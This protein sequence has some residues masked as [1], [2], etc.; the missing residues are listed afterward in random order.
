MWLTGFDAPT[1][2]TLYLDKPL[3]NHT[4]MQTIARA[5][6]VYPGKSAG[7]VIDYINIFSALQ[8]ALGLYGGGQIAEPVAGYNV[9]S[10]AR[11]KRELIAALSTAIV[12]LNEFLKKQSIDLEAIISAPAA[13]FTKLQMLD[14]ASEILLSPDLKDEF[15]AFVLQINRIFK[16]VLPDDDANGYVPHRIAINVIYAQMRQSYLCADASEI[17]CFN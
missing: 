7:Q 3:N 9:D 2:S 17:R 15:T 16:A 14:D 13:G 11:D 10:P 5:N 12:E 8:Q 4:L 1:V 6:R